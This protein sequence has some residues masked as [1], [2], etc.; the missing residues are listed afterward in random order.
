[1]SGNGIQIGHCR[2]CGKEGVFAF[3][4]RAACVGSETVEGN[5][6]FKRRERAV[7]TGGNIAF[8]GIHSRGVSAEKVVYVVQMSVFYNG[9]C[10]FQTFFAGLEDEFYGAVELVLHLHQH[11]GDTKAGNGVSVVTAGMHCS[12][13]DRTEAFFCG[14]MLAVGRLIN[15]QGVNVK[16]HCHG[17]AFSTAQNADDTGH[18]AAGCFDKFF[19]CSLLYGA[20]VRL[21]QRFVGRNAHTLV[22]L[23]HI[24]AHKNFVAK[25]R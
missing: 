7:G 21:F 16:A 19:V 8:F 5:V 22:L 24:F 25:F 13:I 15:A 4:G 1:M 18:S 17:R 2:C 12:V 23:A 20:V 11:S 6:I 10:A 3:L 14:E 9:F